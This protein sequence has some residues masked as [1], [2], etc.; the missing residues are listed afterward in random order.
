MD[1]IALAR[2]VFEAEDFRP[3]LDHLAD[4]VVFE[5]TIPEGTPISGEFRGKQAVVDYFTNLGDVAEFRQEKPLEFFGG[6][7]CVVVLG[8]D[9]FEIKKAAPRPAASTPSSRTSA[10]GRSRAYS[11]SRTCPPSPTPTGR[12]R[13]EA[14]AR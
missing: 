10:P 7:E 4:D 6:G 1:N 5:A 13:A 3:L 11:S 2:S 8:N 9:S 12:T 14:T